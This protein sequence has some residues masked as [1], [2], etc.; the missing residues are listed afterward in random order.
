M[1]GFFSLIIYFFQKKLQL[2]TFFVIFATAIINDQL[3]T[4]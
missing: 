1:W 3:Y 4:L 2:H